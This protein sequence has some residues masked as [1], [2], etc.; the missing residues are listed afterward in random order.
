VDAALTDYAAVQ[1]IN[2][3]S[4]TKLAQS[5]LIPQVKNWEGVLHRD[6]PIEM[7]EIRDGT[8]HTLL[9]VEDAGRPDHWI[10]DGPG[11]ANTTTVCANHGASNGRVSRGAWPMC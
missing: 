5:G 3:S 1:A 4:A 6:R 2:P 9:V 8:S 7:A 10:K 11:P